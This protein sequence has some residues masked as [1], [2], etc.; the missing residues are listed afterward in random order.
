MDEPASAGIFPALSEHARRLAGGSGAI[1]P[2]H[3][4]AA[5]SL[6]RWIAE[7]DRPGAPLHVV[8]VCTGNSRRSIL[9]SSMGN[10]AAAFVGMPGVRFWSGGTEPT[11]FNPRTIAALR[12]IG[13]SVDPTGEE[14]SSDNPIHRVRWGEGLESLEFSKHYADPSNPREG[15]AALMVCG[16]ADAGCPAVG[17]AALRLSMPFEDPKDFDGDPREAEEYAERRDEIGR[18]MLLAMAEARAAAGR[19]G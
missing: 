2:G 13:F 10:L 7:N 5:G 9:G 6:A 8:V 15:F 4:E 19:I 3:R 11:A 16:E 14:A 18:V 17:G 12:A 1:A